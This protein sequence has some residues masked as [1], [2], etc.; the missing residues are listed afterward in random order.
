MLTCKDTVR[1]KRFTPAM[2]RMIAVLADL[3]VTSG[4]APDPLVITSANDSQ[5][6]PHSRHNTDEALDLRTH[7][8]ASRELVIAFQAQLERRLGPQFTVLFENEG[9]EQ[10]HLHA[11]VRKDHTYMFGLEG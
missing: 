2:V 3:A 1:F 8:F 6:D 7:N 10:E 4:A 5:H 9:T 11:Q